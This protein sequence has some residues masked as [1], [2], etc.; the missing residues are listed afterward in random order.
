[1]DTIS[2]TLLN[3]TEAWLP[4]PGRRATVDGAEVS[5]KLHLFFG[6]DNM[7]CLVLLAA[8]VTDDKPVK[9]LSLHAFNPL[10]CNRSPEFWPAASFVADIIVLMMILLINDTSMYTLAC[11]RT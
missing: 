10:R 11:L 8:H 3:F 7:Q 6:L 2:P 9:Y 1:M 4:S 5:G